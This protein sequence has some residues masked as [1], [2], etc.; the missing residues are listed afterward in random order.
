M[1]FEVVDRDTAVA[2]AVGRPDRAHAAHLH[3]PVHAAG[4]LKAGQREGRG[5]ELRSGA[6]VYTRQAKPRNPL[7]FDR[8]EGR[9]NS[10]SEGR[11]T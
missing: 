5:G 4:L 11:T 1:L 9:R 3:L 10:V 8:I 7:H 6:D 2:D